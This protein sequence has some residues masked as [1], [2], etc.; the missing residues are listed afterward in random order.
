MYWN[1]AL[2][3]I[4]TRVI[5]MPGLNGQYIE[6]FKTGTH[7]DSKGNAKEWTE[8]DCI[9]AASN[10]EG[11]TI[12]LGHA[13]KQ[14]YGD[15]ADAK[16]ENGSIWLKP[17]NVD[18]TFNKMMGSGEITN[19]SIGLKRTS[20][21]WGINHIAFLGKSEPAVDGLAMFSKADQE[22]KDAQCHSY[23]FSFSTTDYDIKPWAY[24]YGMR[25]I[26]EALRG[27]REWIIGEHDVETADKLIPNHTIEA[28]DDAKDAIKHTDTKSDFSTD[29]K[30]SQQED[31]TMDKKN[32]DDKQATFSQSDIDSAAADAAIKA[33]DKVRA[34][35]AAE[36]LE[37]DN[38]SAVA[39]FVAA[40]NI[41]PAQAEGAAEFMS[42]LDTESEY[43]F[44][45]AGEGD[46]TETVKTKASAWFSKF[47]A[48]LNTG[49][50]GND[51][52]DDVSVEFSSQQIADYSKK[53]GCDLVEA[54]TQLEKQK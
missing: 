45:V 5:A 14:S 43:E 7:T 21:K 8:Q 2:I 11:A 3:F 52:A 29:A 53:H 33:E 46:N 40:G 10:F 39:G 9:E 32:P 49:L 16:F 20:G 47:V 18:T 1:N 15:I 51:I 4:Q 44:S 24:R 17:N 54:A 34:E 26:S 41:T 23:E 31:N 36:R 35:F 19:R 30:P 37:A 27:V 22:D 48:S 25:S 6:A 13:D 28:V 42:H 38:K 50:T 12:R